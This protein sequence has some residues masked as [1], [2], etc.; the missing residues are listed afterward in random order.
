MISDI[1]LQVASSQVLATAA[2]DRTVTESSVDVGGVALSVMTNPDGGAHIAAGAPLQRDIG[3][4]E[5]LYMIFTNVGG[6]TFTGVTSVVFEVVTSDTELL[7]SPRVLCRTDEIPV[8]SMIAGKQIPLRIQMDPEFKDSTLD[9][10][11]GGAV[12]AVGGTT[13]ANATIDCHIVHGNQAGGKKFYAT[14]FIA[15]P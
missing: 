11:L 3:E 4:G 1:N 6:A 12:S 14:S 9:R 13:L 15:E 10:Y 5:P 7:G 8:A 2:A